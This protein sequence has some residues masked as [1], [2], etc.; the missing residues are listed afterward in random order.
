M[1]NRPP[2]EVFPLLESHMR[3]WLSDLQ[4][5]ANRRWLAASACTV[6]QFGVANA[7]GGF[8]RPQPATPPFAA[9][10][11]EAVA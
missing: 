2:R 3:I 7:G 8:C 10:Q 6:N 5:R 11:R 4:L 9:T 1:G